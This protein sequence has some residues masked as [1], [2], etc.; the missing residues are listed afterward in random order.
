MK[1]E[2]GDKENMA[3]R[4]PGKVKELKQ[5]LMKQINDGRSTL[6]KA[7]KNDPVSIPWVQADFAPN[8]MKNE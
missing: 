8:D 1:T 5:L 4:Y 3:D 2:I 7:Q 6:G